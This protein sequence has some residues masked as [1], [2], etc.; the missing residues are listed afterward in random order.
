MTNKFANLKNYS[1][2]AG[3]KPVH[4]CCGKHKHHHTEEHQNHHANGD[5]CGKHHHDVTQADKL[6]EE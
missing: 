2:C 5:C 3:N 6:T 4:K 1:D